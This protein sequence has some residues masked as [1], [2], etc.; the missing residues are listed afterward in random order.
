[1]NRRDFFLSSAGA[2]TLLS[3]AADAKTKLGLVRSTHSKLAA[4]APLDD[5][6]SYA[7]VRDMVFAA[8][9]YGVPNAGSLA[10]KIKPG[11]WVVIKPNIVYLR[12]HPGYAQG[13][14]TDMRVTRAVLEYVATR[15]RAARVTIAEGGTYRRPNDNAEDN[16]VTQGGQRVNAFNFDWGLNEFPGFHGSVGSL[17]KEFSAQHSGKKF[18]FVDLS[19]DCVRDAGGK[20]RRLEV[21]RAPNGVGAFG[22]R[23]DYFVT[24]TITSCD[25]LI[26]VPVMKVHLQSGI[27]ACLKNYVGTAPR[28][29]YSRP[30]IF[31]NAGL[32]EQHSAGGRIDPFIVDLAAFHPPDYSVVDGIRGLQSQEHSVHREDQTVRSNLVLAGEDPVAADALAARLMGFNS[33]DIEMLHMAARRQMGTMDFDRIDVRGDEPDRNNRAWEKPKQW[34][35]RCN[36]EWRIS[37]RPGSSQQITA[38]FDTLDLVAATK[39]VPASGVVYDAA[40]T[41]NAPGNSRGYVWLGVR[42]KVTARVNGETVAQVESQ[43]RF[44]VGQFQFPVTLRPGANRL[45]FSVVP[46]GGEALISALLTGQRNNGDTIDGIRWQSA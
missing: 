13:D 36:R 22:A 18:D 39:T 2:A 43:T 34:Y 1:M 11:S 21:P 41:V 37:A 28:E 25:F 5:A 8:I 35:G 3:A 45:E 23:S 14:I 20:F 24:N 16:V 17:I 42:G 26:S 40:V 6:L 31:H 30:G 10:Q 44:R 9:D 32:H 29:A 33:Y 46:L 15:S 38:P 7:Q 27:T 19:Y 4:P 12:P